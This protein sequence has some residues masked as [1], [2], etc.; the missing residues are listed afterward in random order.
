MSKPKPTD[1][2][3]IKSD[4][5]TRARCLDKLGYRKRKSPLACLPHR[6]GSTKNSKYKQYPKY[7]SRSVIS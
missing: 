3:H 4:A 6:L 5:E 7:N 1:I 2:S